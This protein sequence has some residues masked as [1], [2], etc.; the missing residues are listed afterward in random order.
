MLIASM[1]LTPAVW[2]KAQQFM[3]FLFDAAFLLGLIRGSAEIIKNAIYLLAITV[4]VLN[5]N[6]HTSHA[7]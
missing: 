3:I 7:S 5:F 1:H 2:V 4:P 6:P